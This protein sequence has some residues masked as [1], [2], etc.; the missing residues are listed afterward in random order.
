M[1]YKLHIYTK[2]S[3]L[4]LKNKD[5]LR[6]SKFSPPGPKFNQFLPKFGPIRQKTGVLKQHNIWLYFHNWGWLPIFNAWF[7]KKNFTY[8]KTDYFSLLWKVQLEKSRE[9]FS[10]SSV[11]LIW[12]VLKTA[13]CQKYTH[14]ILIGLKHLKNWIFKSVLKL[15]NLSRKSRIKIFT[16][17]NKWLK[18]FSRKEIYKQEIQ[19]IEYLLF[20]GELLETWGIYN[21][22]YRKT[23]G[24][25]PCFLQG[26]S[27][28]FVEF[29]FMLI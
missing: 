24:L 7:L 28:K 2:E 17:W 29:R 11:I 19:I 23:A 4:L 18:K 27:W 22:G 20:S 6:F 8:R 26:I 3:F 5:R 16:T 12:H 21:L 10:I 25:T 9:D 1:S 14:S 13:V 15:L